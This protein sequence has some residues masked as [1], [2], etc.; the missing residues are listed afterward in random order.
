MELLELENLAIKENIHLL[1]DNKMSKKAQI[2]NFNKIT[3]IFTNN[4]KISTY[5]EEKCILA[6]ELGH[7]YYDAY[8]SIYSSKQDIERNEYKAFKWKCLACVT[9]QSILDCF[10]KGLFTKYDIA[11]ELNVEVNMVEF[12]INYY[13]N[14]NNLV[15][16]VK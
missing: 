5:K 3:C 14:N 8:Y 16:D 2:V 10:K 12:A 6:E 7:Y 15:I 9:K 11:E 1:T 13:K 4:S